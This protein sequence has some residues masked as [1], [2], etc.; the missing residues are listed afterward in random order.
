MLRSEIR[1]KMVL[2]GYY[3]SQRKYLLTCRNAL[4]QWTR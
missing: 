2:D 3:T 4:S 1:A